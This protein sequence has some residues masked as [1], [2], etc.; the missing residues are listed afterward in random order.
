MQ[1]MFGQPL[2]MK[3]VSDIHG[4][5]TPVDLMPQIGLQ[6]VTAT[7]NAF[8]Y[9]LEV[10]QVSQR[11]LSLFPVLDTSDKLDKSPLVAE[12]CTM[13]SHDGNQTLLDAGY[14]LPTP[15]T[16]QGSYEDQ[17]H[18]YVKVQIKSEAS[19]TDTFFSG[20]IR[21]VIF[22]ANPFRAVN[23]Y[24]VF[25]F[26]LW[27]QTVLRAEMWM[28]L[29]RISLPN[30]Y[31]PRIESFAFP[32]LNCYETSHVPLART[33]TRVLAEFLFNLDYDVSFETH[34][35]TGLMPMLADWGSMGA[36]LALLFGGAGSFWNQWRFTK[37]LNGQDLRRM[38]PADFDSHGNPKDT[39]FK[40]CPE[41]NQYDSLGND[42]VT[43]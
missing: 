30:R 16:L 13:K 29:N 27:K 18:K 34:K 21:M 26:P 43:N 33:K 40:N 12:D 35:Y 32:T 15:L 7:G 17:M 8:A 1:F 25:T 9:Y 10:T 31:Y 11:E 24:H 5:A 23:N 20:D 19:A 14:C 6:L 3:E 41:L 36:F 39:A 28:T 4:D 37:Q 22:D 38:N 42:K 2:I